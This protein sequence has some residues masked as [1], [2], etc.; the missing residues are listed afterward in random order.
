MVPGFPGMCDAYEE[1]DGTAG[2]GVLGV[3]WMHPW[4]RNTW[5]RYEQC[6]HWRAYG[7]GI[8]GVWCQTDTWREKKKE[9]GEEKRTATPASGGKYTQAHM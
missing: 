2:L 3:K 5:T 6:R 4:N 9:P 7:E 8:A 1:A